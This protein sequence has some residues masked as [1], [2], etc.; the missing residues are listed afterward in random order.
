MEETFLIPDDL[1]QLLVD[2]PTPANA[3][4]I[5]AFLRSR[6]RF[7]LARARRRPALPTT[8][9]GRVIAFPAGRAGTKTEDTK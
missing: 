5:L 8:V 4:E 9:P 7:Q 2:A 1:W 6:Q 3:R